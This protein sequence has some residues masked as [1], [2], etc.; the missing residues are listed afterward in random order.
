M[1]DQIDL[2]VGRAVLGACSLALLITTHVPVT[3]WEAELQWITEDELGSTPEFPPVYSLSLWDLWGEGVGSGLATA[4]PLVILAGLCLVAVFA[5]WMVRWVAPV[6]VILL[7]WV[8]LFAIDGFPGAETS[9]RGLCV[10][11]PIITIVVGIW[12]DRARRRVFG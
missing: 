11:V 7:V 8:G 6:G 2:G 9:A 1:R 12:S 5:D 3:R 10:L 4:L